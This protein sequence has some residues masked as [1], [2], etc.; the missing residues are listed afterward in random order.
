MTYDSR[1]DNPYELTAVLLSRLDIAQQLLERNM[2]RAP[3][4]TLGFLNLL[5]ENKDLLLGGGDKNRERIRRMAAFLNMYGGACL[6][7]SLT[8]TE[9]IKLLGGELER[10]LASEKETKA[11]KA[12]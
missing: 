6:L 9:I 1:L 2:G 11:A 12:K 7:D 5:L 8:E 3:A 4:V 10:T